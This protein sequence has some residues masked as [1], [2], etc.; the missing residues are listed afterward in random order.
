MSE[1]EDPEVRRCRVGA[2]LLWAFDTA[3]SLAVLR[4]SGHEAFEDNEAKVLRSHQELY[5][6]PGVRTLGLDAERNDAIRCAKYHALSNALGGLA[7]RYGQESD[8]K[9]WVIYDSPAWIDSPWRPSVA[10][11]AFRPEYQIKTWRAWHANNGPSL[12]NPRLAAVMTQL[13][14]RGDGFD[15]GYFLDTGRDLSESERLQFEWGAAPGP[16]VELHGVTLDPEDWPPIRQAKSW[17]KWVAG[18]VGGRIYQLLEDHELR[19]VSEMVSHA[20]KISLYQRSR[21]VQTFAGGPERD[22]AERAGD[23]L[24]GYGEATGRIS[25][26]RRDGRDHIV[27]LG[28]S[29]I[30][31][32]P[33]FEAAGFPAAVSTAMADSWVSVLSH[34]NPELDI[35]AESPQSGSGSAWRIRRR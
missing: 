5:F 32:A 18:Y 20:L 13:I 15:C 34:W 17:R 27:E 21:E 16:D 2:D 6:L 1:P 29:G 3:L 14:T 28:P 35:R 26:R 11:A 8:V 22:A 30:E 31:T 33:E 7:T 25:A 19:A 12:G 4:A 9:A 24:V 23:V 10:V